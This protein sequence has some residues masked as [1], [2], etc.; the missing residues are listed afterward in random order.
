M[1]A[2]ALLILSSFVAIANSLDVGRNGTRTSDLRGHN[3]IWVL[4]SCKLLELDA[5]RPTAP[6]GRW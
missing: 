3:L 6:L 5:E 1:L 2:D 4:A